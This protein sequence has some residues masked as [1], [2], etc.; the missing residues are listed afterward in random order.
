[1]VNNQIF[2]LLKTGF[3]I[4]TYS[5]FL[6]D[7]AWVPSRNP[8]LNLRSTTFRCLIRPVP[9]VFLLLAFSDQ[10]YLRISAEYNL[11]MSHTAS[12]GSF[13]SLSFLGPVVFA[14]LC[15]RITTSGASLLLDVEGSFAT[16]ATQCVSF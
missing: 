16:S 9:V 10:L 8:L 1:M 5:F 12:T 2:L 11:Q 15:G 13:P 3:R 14:D 6:R 4:K 7:T